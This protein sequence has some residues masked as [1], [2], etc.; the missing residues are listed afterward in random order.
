MNSDESFNEIHLTIEI[1]DAY[2]SSGVL[3]P[4]W[5]QLHQ[6]SEN[7]EPENTSYD[8]PDLSSFLA[9]RPWIEG[10]IVRIALNLRTSPIVQGAIMREK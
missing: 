3:I 8:G 1:V 7:F 9:P 10:T 2:F 6:K 5:E 4:K